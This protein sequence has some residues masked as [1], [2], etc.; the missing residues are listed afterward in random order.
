MC[1]MSMNPSCVST[2]KLISSR[3]S[4]VSFFCNLPTKTRRRM[5]RECLGVE[6]FWR[7]VCL[8]DDE[9]VKQREVGEGEKES[10]RAWD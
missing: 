5:A 9:T 3:G 8:H 4:W 7:K 6:L 2:A 1:F 10:Q